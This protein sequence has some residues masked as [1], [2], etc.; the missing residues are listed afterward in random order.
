MIVRPLTLMFFVGCVTSNRQASTTPLAQKRGGENG[1]L[2]FVKPYDDVQSIASYGFR[3]QGKR[4]NDAA[5]GTVAQMVPSRG[6][7]AVALLGSNDC[8]EW[9]VVKKQ[10]DLIRNNESLRTWAL[11]WEVAPK[12]RGAFFCYGLAIEFDGGDERQFSISDVTLE[13]GALECCE[14]DEDPKCVEYRGR[15]ITTSEGGLEC[16]PWSDTRHHNKNT[17]NIMKDLERRKSWD[18][19]GNYCRNT[20]PGGWTQ[21]AWCYTDATSGRKYKACEIPTCPK[22]ETKSEAWLTELMAEPA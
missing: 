12:D 11:H 3:V 13:T 18:L 21:G 8:K 9:T 20:S 14:K 15:G 6:P 2:L 17:R 7:K 19:Y 1:T 10:S 16:L 4:K 5:N 22:R